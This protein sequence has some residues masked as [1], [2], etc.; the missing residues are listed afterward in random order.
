MTEKKRVIAL[1]FFDGVH[2]GHAALIRKALEIG[3][4]ENL[5]PSVI[6]FDAH[7]QS[8]VSGETVPLINSP[9]DRAGLIRRMF[10][11]DEII[12]LHFDRE[13]ARMSWDS[14]IHHITSEFG[15]R[16]LVAGHDFRFGCGGQGN[17]D[18]LAKKCGELGLGCEII[19]EVMLDGVVS[20]ST[21]IRDLISAGD[22]ERANDFLGH[23]HVL[24]DVVRYGYRLGR[25]LGTPTI[26]MCFGAD[27]LVPAFGVYATRAF[28]CEAEQTENAAQFVTAQAS[29]AHTSTP[30]IS[31]PHTSAPQAST[32]HISTPHTS[33][34]QASALHNSASQASAPQA[35]APHTSTPHTSAPQASSNSNQTDCARGLTGVTNIGVRPTVGNSGLINAETHILDYDGH[36]YGHQVRIEFHTRLR[37]EMK[38]GDKNELKAQIH[39]DCGQARAFFANR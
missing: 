39:K 19:P 23:P 25:T 26:N 33:A 17:S 5:V 22:I 4:Y 2:I 37:P 7:P 24:T 3:E 31:T 16:Y 20:S 30:H 8:L 38:F 15:A 1:G 27:V 29:T 14:F 21:Y 12:F 28:L 35:S 34:P 10:G 36:L 18:L 13:T 32:P 6:T 9:E 11:V